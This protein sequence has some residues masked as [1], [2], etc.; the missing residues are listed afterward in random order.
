MP[1]DGTS[2]EEILQVAT[3]ILSSD[4]LSALSTRRLAAELDVSTMVVYTR[5]GSMPELLAAMV[6]E[7]FQRLMER[8]G[9]VGQERDPIGQLLDLGDAYRALVLSNPQLYAA[10]FGAVTDGNPKE[11]AERTKQ[12]GSV[13]DVFAAAVAR[14]I[15]EGSI[16]PGDPN[17]IAGQVWSAVHGCVMLE[18]AGVLAHDRDVSASTSHPLL[19]T[20]I[21]GLGGS[22]D[23]RK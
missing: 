21:R 1:K 8:L 7:G 18:L 2:R 10:M 5:F 23:G 17:A 20:L 16:G 22:I 13:L 14:A 12:G 19:H 6:D 3:R 11:E 9:E 4:G 15:A